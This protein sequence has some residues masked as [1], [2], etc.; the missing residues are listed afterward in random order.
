MGGFLITI[1]EISV[2]ELNNS[3]LKKEFK[4]SIRSFN[5]ELIEALK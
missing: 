5:T 4:P 3:Q 2:K 1:I